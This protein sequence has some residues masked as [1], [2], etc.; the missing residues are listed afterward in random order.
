MTK[1]L[2][3]GVD[4]LD[5]PI[6]TRRHLLKQEIGM[7]R[8]TRY[9]AEVRLRVQR[10]IGGSETEAQAMKELERCELALDALAEEEKALL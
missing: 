10:R 1:A 2:T 4:T 8:N 9:L 3:N 7:W 5:V 6:E